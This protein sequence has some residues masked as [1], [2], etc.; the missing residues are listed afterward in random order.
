VPAFAAAAF[1]AKAGELTQPV[2]SPFG[3]HLIRVEEKKP[4]TSRELGEVQPEIARKLYTKERSKE[5][6]RAEAEKALAAA[7]SGKQLKDLYPA[8]KEKTE[9]N[10]PNG[11]ARTSKAKPAGDGKLTPVETGPF[12]SGAEAIPQLGSAPSLVSDVFERREPGLLPKVYSI[13]ESLVIAEVTQRE[14][15]SEAEFDQQKDALRQQALSAKRIELRDSF[16]KALKK[17]AT[18]VTNEELVGKTSEAG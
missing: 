4:A 6:A 12:N 7:K 8:A 18:I 15:P 11:K 14:R 9:P 16:L 17:K 13:G 5:L 3:Y 2:L 10:D 1:G